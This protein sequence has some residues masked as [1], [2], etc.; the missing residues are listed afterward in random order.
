MG[1]LDH[2]VSEQ[3]S[4]VKEA[5]AAH[6]ASDGAPVE[7]AIVGPVGGDDERVGVFGGLGGRVAEEETVVLVDGACIGESGRI[8]HTDAGAASDEFLGQFDGRTVADVIGVGLE[9]E[10]QHGNAFTRKDSEFV[11]DFEDDAI[12]L[13]PVDMDGRLDDGHFVPVIARHAQEGQGI[14]WKTRPA[15]SEAGLQE[16]GGNAAIHAHAAADV[17]HVSAKFFAQ[18]RDF[19]GIADFECQKD[20]GGVL[21]HF[22]GN[23]VGVETLGSGTGRRRGDGGRRHER[24]FQNGG[25]EFGQH[26]EGFVIARANDKAIRIER[27][28]E[29][30]SFAE[31]LG[32]GGEMEFGPVA[33]ARLDGFANSGFDHPVDAHGYRRFDNDGHIACG[34][35]RGADL[36]RRAVDV[37]QVGLPV[38][39]G[40]RAH[41]DE[42]DIGLAE[43]FAQFGGEAYRLE[44]RQERVEPSLGNRC[45][46]FAKHGYFACVDIDARDM[47]SDIRQCG[48]RIDSHIPRTNGDHVHLRISFMSLVSRFLV[49]YAP[50]ADHETR[51]RGKVRHI[52]DRPAVTSRS[53]A[54][55]NAIGEHPSIHAGV[56]AR[57]HITHTMPRCKQ[58]CR[59]NRTCRGRQMA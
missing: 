26:L 31:K 27:V 37:V 49:L 1:I 55:L 57:A 12:E 22:G 18:S 15:P 25:K 54:S 46:A 40:G 11:E 8:V 34:R 59:R 56:S 6:E 2:R 5:G 17:G 36:R 35:E 21:D 41:G 16:I 53:R 23:G 38:R 51:P 58:T 10:P 47:M 42:H 45:P 19:V 33:A 28:V 52:P 20:I 30:T 14:L 44:R 39:S 50:C 4:G 7:G 29:G 32:V 9:R 3:I 24:L 13:S 48:S 43:D